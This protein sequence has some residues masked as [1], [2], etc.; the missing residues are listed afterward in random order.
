MN[1]LQSWDV[2]A[3]GPDVVE[4]IEADP[5]RGWRIVWIGIVFVVLCV[6]LI[7]TATTGGT[8]S[9]FVYAAALGGGIL[10]LLFFGAGLAYL[11]PRQLRNGP[12]L[13]VTTAGIVDQSSVLGVGFIAWAEIER[14]FVP[15]LWPMFVGLKLAD[16]KG[17]FARLG[18][19]KRPFVMLNSRLNRFFPGV[20]GA[21]IFFPT[22]TLIYTTSELADLLNKN[23]SRFG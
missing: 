6:V 7:V 4:E 15:T 22:N 3:D 10:G 19:I 18:V 11:L 9:E 8:H 1:V 20:D 2:T 13:I 5:G 23:L 21:D 17:V 12:L 16:R 14:I